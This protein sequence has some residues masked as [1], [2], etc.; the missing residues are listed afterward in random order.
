MVKS[1]VFSKEKLLSFILTIISIFFLIRLFGVITDQLN[2]PFDLV[3]EAP[4]LGVI[5]FIQDGGNPYNPETFSKEPFIFTVYT[6]L[7]HYI[8]AS[9]PTL[10]NNPYFTGRVVSMIAMLLSAFSLFFIK[11][12]KQVSIIPFIAFGLFFLYGR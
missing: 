7:Y 10:D 6:P 9:L 3:F 12:N 5:R 4:N 8:V 2:A 11:R 1:T